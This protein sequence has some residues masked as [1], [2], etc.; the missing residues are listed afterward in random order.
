MRVLFVTQRFPGLAPRG[1]QQRALQQ[2]RHL[3]RRHA[4]TLLSFEAAPHA[5]PLAADVAACCERVMTCTE[6]RWRMALRAGAGLFGSRPLQTAMCD[7]HPRRRAFDDLLA[8]GGFDLVHVQLARLGGLLESPRSTPCVLDLVDALSLNMARRAQLDRPPLRWLARLEAERLARYERALC[9]RARRVSVSSPQDLAAIGEYAHLRRVDNGVDLDRFPF[10]GSGARGDELVFV[11]NLGYFPNI[12]AVQWFASTVWPILRSRRPTTRLR[13]VGSRPHPALRTLARNTP[14]IDLV[15][16]V[17]EV[18][19]HL[20]RAAIAVVPLRA[21]S[22][23]QLKVLEAMAA[24]TPVVATEIAAAGLDAT[25]GT[26]WRVASDA[27]G[28]ADAILELLDDRA[29]A[30]AMAVAA[31]T[32]VERGHTWARSAEALERVWFEAVA[33]R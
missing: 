29:K 32:F 17:A 16:P 21:G 13:L 11:G 20:H 10:D 5:H 18:C 1:D 26:H 9:T 24:G 6:S 27:T 28:M 30:Q 19:P 31:R 2:L 22:G 33:E 3:G 23:Q 14:G 12:D 4:I 15:G 25:D 8:D 7:S